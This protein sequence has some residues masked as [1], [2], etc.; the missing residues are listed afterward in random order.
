M[1]AVILTMSTSGYPPFEYGVAARPLPGELKSGDLPAVIPLP[2]GALV[3][4]VDGLGHGYEATLAAEI[5]VIT[6]RAQPHLPVD[7]IV[8]RCHEALIKTRG[9]AM[10]IASLDWRDETMTWLAIGNVAGLL[11]RANKQGGFE[12]EHILMRGGIVGHRLPS[13][14]P[15]TLRLHRGD[16]LIFATDGICEGFQ[17]A[18][19]FGAR[20]QE[21]ADRILTRYGQITDDALVLVGRWN[22]PPMSWEE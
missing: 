1:G 12:R 4:V 16:L 18:V 19:R 20:A 11:L 14:R 6:L 10:S 8:R 9:V 7:H 13:L 2:Q 17:E 3:A 15:A 22:G 21:I 5:A